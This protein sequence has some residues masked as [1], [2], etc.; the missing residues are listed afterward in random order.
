MFQQPS[1]GDKFTVSDHVGSLCLF[2][3]HEVRSGITTTFGEKEAIACDI[4][5][6]QGP[7]AGEICQDALIFQGALIGS[8]RRAAGGDPVLGRIAQGVAKPGQQPP[9]VLAEFTD[10]DAALAQTWIKAHPHGMQSPAGT[11]A[12]TAP[13]AATAAPAAGN[14]G[15]D[16][17]T[18]PP[19]VQ[20]LLKQS[21]AMPR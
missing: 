5:V 16:Y 8:L 17:S 15:V 9:Y 14:G 19:E 2:Y 13:T 4:H 20:E 21:G 3:V 7:G 12:A 1:Q 11:A 6:L 10:A 18:L